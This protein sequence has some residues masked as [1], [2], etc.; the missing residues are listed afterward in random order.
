MNDNVV[1]GIFIVSMAN[2][3]GNDVNLPMNLWIDEGKEY[4]RGGHSK[5]LKFQKDHARKIHEWNF[6][7]ITLDGNIIKETNYD[8][9]LSSKDEK[10]V[11]NFTRNNAYALSKVAD[12]EITDD[13]FKAVLIKGGQPASEAEIAEQIRK[14]DEY[15]RDSEGDN[16][17]NWED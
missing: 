2:Y 13:E 9:D 6:A 17:L 10:M 11:M 1:E 15:I 4:V 3:R 7:S 12:F 14:V 16:V 8:S 5:R